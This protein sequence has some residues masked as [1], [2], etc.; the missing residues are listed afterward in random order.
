MIPHN[1]AIVIVAKCP[2]RGKSKTRLIPLLGE[3]GAI[4]FAK[5]MLSDVL[6]TVDKCSVLRYVHKVLLY[7]PGNEEGFEIMQDL[8]K[9]LDLSLKDTKNDSDRSKWLL[10]PMLQGDLTASD[11]GSKLEDALVRVRN[12]MSSRGG[13]VF[14]GM[15]APILSLDDIVTGLVEGESKSSTPSAILCPAAD[16]G[17]GM[18]CV[19]PEADPSRTFRNMYWS[20]SLTAI[21]QCKNLSDQNIM[22]K[23]GK[24]MLDIDDPSDV[25]E[26]CERLKDGILDHDDNGGV[27]KNLGFNNANTPTTVT[28]DHPSCQFTSQVLKDMKLV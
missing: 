12:I 26:F 24:M 22:V 18:L 1:G 3:D 17:Y 16:G 10:L 15:D 11:L 5:S 2:I 21:S 6:S 7:A 27:N 19:P 25:E 9:E 14:L 20:H 8:L 28:S 4:A 13:V 23:I